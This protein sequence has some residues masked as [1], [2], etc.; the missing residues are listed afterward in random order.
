VTVGELVDALVELTAHLDADLD[1]AIYHG[2]SEDALSIRDVT[3]YED[4]DE[5]Q[6]TVG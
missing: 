6:I 1:V 5:V 3:V 2:D 4:R